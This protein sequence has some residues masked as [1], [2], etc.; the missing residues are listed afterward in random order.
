ME[1]L[2]DLGIADYRAW[3]E[4]LGAIES[5][6]RLADTERLRLEAMQQ[7]IAADRA[8]LLVAALVDA[9]RRHV[10]DR[11]LLDAIG[12]EVERLVVAHGERAELGTGEPP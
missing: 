3:T 7:T 11:K 1:R 10:D 9:V 4:L 12:G 2:V 8:M 5:R 6:R